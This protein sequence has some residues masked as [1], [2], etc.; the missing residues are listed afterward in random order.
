MQSR[1]KTETEAVSIVD[2]VFLPEFK[3]RV[4]E[5]LDA[6][7]EVYAAHFTVEEMREL[8]AW[9]RTPVGLKALG[10]APRIATESL[11]ASRAWSER[12]ASEA[13]A[14]HADE[15]RRRGVGF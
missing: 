12:V 7:A 6:M 8:Q 3:A 13:L 4:G 11:A 10:V 2:D 14:K 9:Q 1:G 15:L 5:L